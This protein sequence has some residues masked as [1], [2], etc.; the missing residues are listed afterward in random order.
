MK[1]KLSKINI[2]ITFPTGDINPIQTAKTIH[3]T[4]TPS[5]DLALIK[6]IYNS[7]LMGLNFSTIE[8]NSGKDFD[9]KP[10]LWTPDGSHR[11][12]PG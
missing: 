10:V 1:I 2:C 7:T 9:S 6:S 11:Q 5:F 12:T 3:L 4:N 8:D